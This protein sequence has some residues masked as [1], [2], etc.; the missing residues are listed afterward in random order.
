MNIPS[1]VERY[2]KPLLFKN[3]FAKTPYDDAR[4]RAQAATN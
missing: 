1:M 2:A 3:L 4:V